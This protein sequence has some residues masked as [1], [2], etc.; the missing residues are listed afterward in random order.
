MKVGPT[1]IQ[2]DV[3][4]LIA[5]ASQ[6]HAVGAELGVVGVPSP[7]RPFQPTSAAVGG[8]HAAICIAAA[9]LSARAHETASAVEAGA[10]GYVANE[11][12]AAAEMAAV[13]QNG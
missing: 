7:G 8:V 5:A 3:E 11:A 10:G 6:W 2:V 9:T 13:L 1:G 4:Q 12:T